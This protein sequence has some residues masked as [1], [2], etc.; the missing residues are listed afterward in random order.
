MGNI[1]RAQRFG[2]NHTV[3]RLNT[4]LASGSSRE[5][6][7]AG[8]LRVRRRPRSSGRVHGRDVSRVGSRDTD[9]ARGR[10]G[11]PRLRA[12]SWHKAQDARPRRSDRD[13]GPGNLLKYALEHAQGE[14][15]L[16]SWTGR[17]CAGTSAPP[18]PS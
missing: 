18:A 2:L 3:S 8:S 5:K 17:T 16:S 1:W 10:L 7:S 12:H 11:G 4:F 15:G 13:E 6:S 14:N 9:E